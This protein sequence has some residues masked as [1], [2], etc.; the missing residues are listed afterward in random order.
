M[1]IKFF[2]VMLVILAAYCVTLASGEVTTFK[3]GPFT[4]SVDLDMPCN[5]MKNSLS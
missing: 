3:T 2:I 1:K 4:V 5:D